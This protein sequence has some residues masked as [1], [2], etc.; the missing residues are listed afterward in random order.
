[1][2]PRSLVASVV[3]WLGTGC[4]V[5]GAAPIEHA[6]VQLKGADFHSTIS[7]GLWFIEHFSPYC[8][9]CKQFAPAWRDLVEKSQP[10][11]DAGRIQFGQ[12][13]C[14][15]QGD[16]CD[17]N[18]VKAYPD[19]RMFKDGIS[20]TPFVEERS[21]DKLTAFIDK[22]IAAYK[23]VKAAPAAAVTEKSDTSKDKIVPDLPVPIQEAKVKADESVKAVR[24]PAVDDTPSTSTGSEF[25]IQSR[26]RDLPNIDGQLLTLNAT[27]LTHL[28][29]PSATAP[30]FIKF[31]APWCSHCKK[32]APAWKD[33]AALL[34]E[35]VHVAEF[36]C[37]VAEH[38]EAC[39]KADIRGFPT[40][41]F[42]HQGESIEYKGS[43][44]LTQMQAFALKAAASFGVHDISPGVF[45]RVSQEEDIFFLYLYPKTA[46]EEETSLVS[47]AAKVLLGGAKIFKTS[48]SDLFERYKLPL[49]EAH[50]L[51][52]KDYDIAQ[53]LKTL[54]MSSVFA[55]REIRA[56]LFA[57]RLPSLGELNAQYFK[58]Y[59]EGSA[60]MVL[61]ALSPQKLGPDGMQ[62]RKDELRT[63]A[64]LYSD[65]Q[66]QTGDL[67][68][69]NFAWMD[70]DQW[71]K[72]LQQNYKISIKGTDVPIVIADPKRLEYFDVDTH[73]RRIALSE[74]SIFATLSEF[75]RGLLSPKSSRGL[76][77]RW[78]F[79]LQ[80]KMEGGMHFM[81]DNPVYFMAVVLVM[82][83]LIIWMI[84]S[85]LT[86]LPT[87]STKGTYTPMRP[88]AS[89]PKSL[90]TAP[91]STVKAD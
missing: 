67:K 30:I 87:G 65:S 6:G 78:A 91:V 31:F 51:V 43:R 85:V 12:V 27:G 28:I 35:R 80:Q 18:S 25:V 83:L 47:E 76:M 1:M 58:D 46:T 75:Q 84:Y 60:Y 34:K 26:S 61:A 16:L 50:I 72:W 10:L 54:H 21:E 53:P 17:A 81:L 11:I 29:S 49:T 77:D 19:L 4:L 70:A 37:D 73:G 36:D 68:P 44:S 89:G 14:A 42:F 32:L 33:L 8:H 22:E 57:N 2:L 20:S 74:S 90:Y 52:F 39:R 64:R 15:D 38:R 59:T 79:T 55:D 45:E 5:A 66:A 88:G 86:E 40:L 13:D 62:Q 24:P 82:A 69:V 23:P 56:W 63:L 7:S 48:S 9:H 71:S 41:T 3:L